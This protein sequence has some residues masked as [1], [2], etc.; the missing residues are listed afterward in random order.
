MEPDRLAMCPMSGFLSVSSPLNSPDVAVDWRRE[1]PGALAD[2][3]LA[4]IAVAATGG[5]RSPGSGRGRGRAGHH[6]L[7]MAQRDDNRVSRAMAPSPR[8]A[9]EAS[10]GPDGAGSPI[11]GKIENLPAQSGS[12]AM[13]DIPTLL[14][15]IIF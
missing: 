2:V 6:Q 1:T 15:I 5:G 11:A 13:H 14:A 4:G 3:F 7:A 10:G 9:A 12:S 8:A